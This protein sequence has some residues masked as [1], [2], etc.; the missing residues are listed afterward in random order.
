MMEWQIDEEMTTASL[1]I[2]PFACGG[3]FREW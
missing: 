2:G 1:P 3:S